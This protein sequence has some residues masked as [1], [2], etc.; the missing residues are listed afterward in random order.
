MLLHLLLGF[1]TL[2]AASSVDLIHLS[3]LEYSLTEVEG[4]QCDLVVFGQDSAINEEND[5][6]RPMIQLSYGRAVTDD[7]FQ[8]SKCLILL[9]SEEV[10]LNEIM[11]SARKFN[12][13][14]PIGIVYEVKNLSV[15]ADLK[16][17]PFPIIF[18]LNQSKFAEQKK[19]LRDRISYSLRRQCFALPKYFT[20]VRCKN[21]Y[22]S[23]CHKMSQWKRTDG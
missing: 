15:D 3:T 7:A 23:Q 2:E 13:L 12:H 18:R 20:A 9:M 19:T 10:P 8:K 14:K 4:T 11:L 16:N 21:G 22:L 5:F 17:W 6:N 1:F